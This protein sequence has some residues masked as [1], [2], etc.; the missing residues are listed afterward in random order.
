MKKKGNIVTSYNYKGF[1]IY[2][3]DDATEGYYASIADCDGKYVDS[4]P[5]RNDIESVKTAAENIIDQR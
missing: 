2:I 4:T 5:F 1:N 3:C